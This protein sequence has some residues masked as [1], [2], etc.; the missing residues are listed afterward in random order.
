VIK[1]RPNAWIWIVLW[2]VALATR[3]I[4]VFWLPNAEQDGYSYAE[5]IAWLTANL[6]HL[7][8]QDLYGFWLP[9][10]QLASACLNVCLG[11]ALLAGKILSSVCGAVSCVFVF[12]ITKRLSNNLVLA[13]VMFALIV[14][15]PLHVLYSAA[16]MTDVP[17][18]CL[19]LASLWFLL[20]ER[21]IGAAVFAALAG[22]VRLESWAL[23]PLLPLLQLFRQRRVSP[24]VLVLLI[25]PPLLWL[26]ISY[27]ARGDSFAYF[28]D[29]TRYHAN[30][31]DFYPT[32][33]GFALA[34]LKVDSD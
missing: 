21:W 29:R 22:S 16:C 14:L 30:Y 6:A 5:K 12:A 33:H 3:L 24:V 19:V 7:H 31:L 9:L 4:A 17:H 26:A 27:S 23:I 11:N 15:N 13:C 1:L 20:Q 10:F 32:R 25:L 28:A 2:L 34:D 18:V 8:W